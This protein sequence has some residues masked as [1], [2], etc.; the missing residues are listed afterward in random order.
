MKTALAIPHAPWIPERAA[1]MA[2]LRVTLKPKFADGNRQSYD[3]GF[4]KEFTEKG[5]Y[6]DR[7][8]T[9]IQWGVVQKEANWFLTLQDDVEIP[10]FP[11]FHAYLTAMQEA[12]PNEVISLAATHTKGPELAK[13]G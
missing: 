4:Y 3:Y 2:E 7:F 10:P 8:L 12:W 1:A 11:D 6:L 9:M 5:H 13:E